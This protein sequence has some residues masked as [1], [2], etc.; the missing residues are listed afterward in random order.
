[1]TVRTLTKE[2]HEKKWFSCEFKYCDEGEERGGKKLHVVERNSS[3]NKATSRVG[4][5]TIK[6][7]LILR[8]K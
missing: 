4:A 1:M 3:S 5:P 2:D 6:W 7:I 8:M